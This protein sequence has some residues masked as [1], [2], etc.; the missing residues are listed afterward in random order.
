MKKDGVSKQY[1]GD[2][3]AANPGLIAQYPGAVV[4]MIDSDTRLDDHSISKRIGLR[5][6]R[7]LESGALFMS[8]AEL[9]ELATSEKPF[10]RYSEI[11]LLRGDLPGKFCMRA[12]ELLGHEAALLPPLASDFWQRF[13]MSD[14]AIGI[15]DG[16]WM[17]Y[18][19][20]DEALFA[21]LSS[22]G[23]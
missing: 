9:A 11:W 14:V 12:G 3:L 4:T 15:G 1:C 6:V 16:D 7:S 21:T 18:A 23:D 17:R 10:V 8:G 19:V 20:D 2:W 13:E 5:S 22:G